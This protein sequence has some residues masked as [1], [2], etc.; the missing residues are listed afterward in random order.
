MGWAS[1]HNQIND[2]AP[3]TQLASP[4]G[5]PASAL[6]GNG[7]STWYSWLGFGAVW[8]MT[9]LAAESIYFD[10]DYCPNPN[11]DSPNNRCW[12]PRI[13]VN[14]DITRTLQVLLSI[15]AAVVASTAIM[16]FHKPSGISGDPTSIAAVAAIMG[17]PDVAQDFKSLDPEIQTKELKKLLKDKKYKLGNYR[18][19]DGT[20]G[21]G[22][23]PASE[24]DGTAQETRL[25]PRGIDSGSSISSSRWRP[26]FISGWKE[27]AML[28]DIL[29]FFFLVVILGVTAAYF[30]TVNRS[31]LAKVL[32][33]KSIGRRLVFALLGSVAASNWARLGR[34]EFL[35][36]PE[37]GGE[38]IR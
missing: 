6:F 10:T 18:L 8:V 4:N 31:G 21:H 27:S 32:E 3:F 5:A 23:I 15:S 28:I 25:V 9:P 30:K 1:L 12:P 13:S 14:T 35:R 19:A 37:V 24:G 2:L 29:F 16:W 22:I 11:N 17:H 33:G 7:L 38:S 36:T 20:E 34:G 26:S